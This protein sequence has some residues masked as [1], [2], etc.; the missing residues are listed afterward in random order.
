MYKMRDNVL[1]Y[2]K[3]S[4]GELRSGRL[5]CCFK[6]GSVLDLSKVTHLTLRLLTKNS[7]TFLSVIPPG[8]QSKALS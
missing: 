5:I 4:G 8:K 6:D 7:A 2:E 3:Y 1:S